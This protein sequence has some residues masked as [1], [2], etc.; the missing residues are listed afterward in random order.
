MNVAVIGKGKVGTQLARIFNTRPVDSRTLE[1]L[2]RNADII[3]IAVSDSAVKAVAD[4]LKGYS[5]IVAHTSGSV[6][7]DVLRETDA[8][9]YGVF[10]P[11]Q[12]ISKNRDLSPSD[13]PLL[14]EGSDAGTLQALFDAASEYGFQNVAEADS[15]TRGKIHLAGVFACNFSNAMIAVSQSILD[16]CGIDTQIITPLVKETIE[17]LRSLPAKEAQTGPAVRNDIPTLEKHI[18]LL[19]SLGMDKETEIYNLITDYIR[20]N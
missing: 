7:K 12:T 9:G 17:K 3:V 14:L 4:S 6:P 13:I 20:E 18:A 10:Y 5:G 19:R 2:D 11:F 8:K 16:E 1:G 15:V